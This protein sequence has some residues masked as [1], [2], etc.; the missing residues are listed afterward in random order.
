MGITPYAKNASGLKHAVGRKG[1][2]LADGRT[3]CFMTRIRICFCAAGALVKSMLEKEVE[4]YLCKKVKKELQG[5]VLKFVSPGLNGVPDRIVLV[6]I[7]R[8]YFVE[9]KAPGKKLR[10]LQKWVCG[11]IREMGFSVLEIDTKE[12]VDAFISEVQKNG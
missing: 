12:K 8:I 6:P 11:H 2:H 5:W 10:S 9:L 3:V 7:G 4:Q 1:A